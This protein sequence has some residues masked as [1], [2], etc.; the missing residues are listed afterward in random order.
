MPNNIRFKNRL[1]AAEQ[2]AVAL[3]KFAKEKVVIFALP[4]G[5]VPMGKEIAKTIDCP[6]D[7]VIVRKIGHPANPEYAVGVISEDGHTVLNKAEVKTIEP[8]WFKKECA[9]QKAEAKRRRELYLK[10]R[11]PLDV[12]GKIAII[13][14]DGIATGLTMLGAIKEIKHKNPARVVVAVPFA[15]KDTAEIIKK[16]VDEFI[17]LSIP[18]VYLGAVGAYY[19]EFDQVSDEEVVALLKPSALVD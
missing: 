19:D 12:T 3:R 10:G 14:D 16:E 17:T 4:R 7:L 11:T 6:L 2:L 13:V 5:G 9:Q 1:D 8:K 18:D 15:P